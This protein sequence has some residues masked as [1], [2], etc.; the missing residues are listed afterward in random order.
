MSGNTGKTLLGILAGTAIGAG[1]GVLF[2]PDKGSVTRKKI[3]DGYE[4]EKENLKGKFNQ[5]TGN[6]KNKLSNVKED[7]GSG[8]QSLSPTARKEDEIGSMESRLSDLKNQGPTGK[9]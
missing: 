8:Y 1:L 7:L 2:A 5:L 4:H 9:R 6:L 3:Q